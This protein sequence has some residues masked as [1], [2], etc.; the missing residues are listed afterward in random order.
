MSLHSLSKG[1]REAV[2]QLLHA[3]II[4]DLGH[5]NPERFSEWIREMDG[6][7]RKVSMARL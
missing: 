6:K 5:F 3:M 7:F 2:R 4:S 1:E